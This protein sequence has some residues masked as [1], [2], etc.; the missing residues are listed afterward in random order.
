MRLGNI[1]TIYFVYENHIK[2]NIRNPY[3][4]YTEFTKYFTV[5]KK[6]SIS[7][8]PI[9]QSKTKNSRKSIIN[10]FTTPSIRT[11]LS[12]SPKIPLVED[13]LDKTNFIYFMANYANLFDENGHLVSDF[14]PKIDN[15]LQAN[16]LLSNMN[17]NKTKKCPNV[18][19]KKS[20][21]ANNATSNYDCFLQNCKSLINFENKRED[22]ISTE[23]NNNTPH[24]RNPLLVSEVSGGI[25]LSGSQYPKKVVTGGPLTFKKSSK[26]MQ[27]AEEAIQSTS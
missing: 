23:V 27:N 6:E 10:R 5:V 14:N 4:E 7:I 19:T 1:N 12:D 25:T 15:N 3:N 18:I 26:H 9:D 17:S 22:I 8:P 13:L 24:K 20:V 2:N 11:N 21:N 16:T